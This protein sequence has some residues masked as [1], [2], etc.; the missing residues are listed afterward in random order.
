MGDALGDA[1]VDGLQVAG[2]EV[3]A[4]HEVHAAPVAAVQGIAG[5]HVQR[6]GDGF[7]LPFGHDQQQRLG[8]GRAQRWKNAGF[9]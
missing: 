7:A 4:R 6:A 5:R 3:Q 8:H 2:L 1:V 9:R